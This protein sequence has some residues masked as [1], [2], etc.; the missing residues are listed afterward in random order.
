MDKMTVKAAVIAVLEEIQNT[1]GFECPAM[2]GMT[3]PVLDLPGFKSVLWPTAI[4][5]I[6]DSI[7]FEIPNDANIFIT[8]SGGKRMSIDEITEFVIGL[9]MKG[10]K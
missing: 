3:V 5:M 6:S 10:Q 9:A 2:T 8:K 1:S 4:D 7:D